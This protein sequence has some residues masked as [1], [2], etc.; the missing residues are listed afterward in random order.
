LLLLPLL[1]L[2]CSAGP[3]ASPTL[4]SYAGWPPNSSYP[5]IPYPVSTEITVGPNRLLV[6][7]LDASTNTSTASADHPVQL[8]LYDMAHDADLPALTTDAAYLPTIATLPGLYRAMVTFAHAG[9]WGLEAIQDPG[10]AQERMGRVLFEVSASGTTPAIG[11]SVQAENTPTATGTAGIAAISTDDDP[12]PDFYTTSIAGALAAHEPFVV[13]FAT[14]LFC[15]SATCGPTL[16]LVKQV[17]A[18][19]KGRLTFIHV[20]PYQLTLTD[21]HLQPVLSA[22]NNPIPIQPVEDWGLQTEPY[23][24]VVGADGKLTAKFEGIAS[25]EELRAAFDAVAQ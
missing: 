10:T 17:A 23:V 6:N 12:D 22:D 1:T 15:R 14:P 18:D 11:A 7:L 24:F 5:L 19:Y 21:G 13:V 16:D 3:A 20:E 9:N 8:R 2:A 4:A 25:A